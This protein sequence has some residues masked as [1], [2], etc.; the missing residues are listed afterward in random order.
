ML[1]FLTFRLRSHGCETELIREAAGHMTSPSVEDLIMCRSSFLLRKAREH[2]GFTHEVSS[3]YDYRNKISVKF[4]TGSRSEEGNNE[5]LIIQRT[6]KDR[7]FL[8]GF[9]RG[10]SGGCKGMC[11]CCSELLVKKHH[12]TIHSLE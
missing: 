11:G 9:L 6:N 5:L 4:P 2:A 10:S 3:I 8:Q 1:K 7:A 12:G